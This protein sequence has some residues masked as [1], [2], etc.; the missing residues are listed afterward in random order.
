M[1]VVN[2]QNGA[3][4]L[5]GPFS[6]IREPLGRARRLLL[7]PE[8]LSPLGPAAGQLTNAR[9]ALTGKCSWLTT[10]EIGR[11]NVGRQIA[12]PDEPRGIVAGQSKLLGGLIK[13]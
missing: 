1:F 3:S 6:R 4:Y 9:K 10:L 8:Q 13:G 12:E 2:T 5:S 11:D 7:E